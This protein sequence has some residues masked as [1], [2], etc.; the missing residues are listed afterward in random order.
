MFSILSLSIPL[1][2]DSIFGLLNHIS[3]SWYKIGKRISIFQ[4][5]ISR[6]IPFVNP[7]INFNDVDHCGVDEVFFK[8]ILLNIENFGRFSHVLT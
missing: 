2:Y 5:P 1:Y 3:L 6:I 8:K 4:I 7:P